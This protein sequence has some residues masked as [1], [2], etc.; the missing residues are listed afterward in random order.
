MPS[1][2][3]SVLAHV[4]HTETQYD[5]LLMRGVDRRD[6]RMIVRDK[7]DRVLDDWRGV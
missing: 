5:E 7:I 3:L 6:A 2:S 1:P 4:R